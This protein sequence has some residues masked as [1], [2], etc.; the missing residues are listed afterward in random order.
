MGMLGIVLAE[1]ARPRG[2]DAPPEGI[3]G[4]L[5]ANP[6]PTIGIVALV[7]GTLI[8]MAVLNGAK[9]AELSAAQRS[10]LKQRVMQMV[11]R[12]MSGVTAV[13]VAE[14]LQLEVSAS[15][16]LL[17]ELTEDGFLLKSEGTGSAPAHFRLRIRG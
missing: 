15:G 14:E 12:R 4:V 3:W 16:L 9:S 11:R 6:V 10:E 17:N 1:A 5:E 13:Q 8:V 2:A 7:I